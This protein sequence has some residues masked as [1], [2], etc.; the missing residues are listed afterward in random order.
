ME[1][2]FEKLA[3]YSHERLTDKIRFVRINMHRRVFVAYE[4]LL[5]LPAQRI[6][7]RSMVSCPDLV[8][9]AILVIVVPASHLL[10]SGD[11]SASAEAPDSLRREPGCAQ[12]LSGREHMFPI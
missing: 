10:M 4:I 9:C 5:I 7:Q 2:G 11:A 8:I 12:L 6:S 1:S 3:Q